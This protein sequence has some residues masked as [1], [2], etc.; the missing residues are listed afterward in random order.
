[1]VENLGWELIK[2]RAWEVAAAS[3][4]MTVLVSACRLSVSHCPRTDDANFVRV[5]A[6]RTVSQLLKGPIKAR[7][8][9]TQPNLAHGVALLGPFL[10][11]RRIQRLGMRPQVDI[12]GHDDDEAWSGAAPGKWGLVSEVV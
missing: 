11:R 6:L 9:C 5:G 3:S 1:M 4:E 10:Q 12:V 2:V 7:F 8:Q